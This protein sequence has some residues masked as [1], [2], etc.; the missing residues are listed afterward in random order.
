MKKQQCYFCKS[1]KTKKNGSYRRPSDNR[2][3]ARFFCKCCHRSFS[4]QAFKPDYRLKKRSKN[5]IVFRLLA[6]GMAQREIARTIGMSRTSIARR[7]VLYGTY[8]HTKLCEY[9][10]SMTKTSLV[11]FDEMESFQ[12]TKCKPLTMPIA[13]EEST[14]KILSIS[15]GQIAAK[16]R[17]A[18]IS[19][20]KYGPRICERKISLVKM[21]NEL[22]ECCCKSPSIKT[23]KSNHYPQIIK[24]TW[25]GM[26]T[27]ITSKGKKSAVTGQ[28]EMKKGGFD[29]LFLLNHTFAMIRDKLKCLTRQTWCTVKKVSN[30]IYLLYIYAH[31]HNQRVEGCDRPVL[32]KQQ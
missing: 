24:Q 4:E 31:F 7:V 9:R 32:V 12:H 19:V 2:K 14:R 21:D 10:Q 30:L 25:K 20:K 27:H 5:E 22:K 18:K 11:L 6:G 13:V 28:G 23:D 26:A 29:D 3:F 15:V 8:A 1:N 17:L 16:G